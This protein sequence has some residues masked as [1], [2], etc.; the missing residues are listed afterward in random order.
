MAQISKIKLK[1]KKKKLLFNSY[2]PI[3]SNLVTQNKI[4]KILFEDGHLSHLDKITFSW[5]I[6][7]NKGQ[8]PTPETQKK[9]NPISEAY[10]P[11]KISH[12]SFSTLD[13]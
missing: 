1:K 3:Y 11:W 8:F 6:I 2:K 7:F 10:S 12:R 4:K 5:K 13:F 9:K